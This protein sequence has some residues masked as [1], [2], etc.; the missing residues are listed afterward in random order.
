MT[1]SLHVC[2]VS[3]SRADYG[4]LLPPMRAIQ[5]DPAFRLSM[6]LTGQ[7]L[8]KDAG[9]TAARVRAD[10]FDI[11]AEIDM[12]LAGDDA[13]NVIHACGR[14]LD[15]MAD[16]LARL[17]PDLL[18]VLGDRY[19]ILCCVLAATLARIPIAHI[20]GGDI[21]EGAFDEGF[22]H[23][24][25]KMS[26]LHFVTNADAAVRVRQM[27][28][29]NVYVTGSPALD[30]IRQTP[31]LT[32]D[33][34]FSRLGLAPAK[35][36]ILVTFHP[37]TL[38]KDSLAQFDEVLAALASLEDTAIVIT[39]SNADPEGRQIDTRAKAFVRTHANSVFRPSLGIECYLSA[40]TH[41]DIVAGNS[42][43]G[44]TE[45]PS[46][47][48]PTVNIGTRQHGRPKA[49]SVI[50]TPSQ[51]RDILL[52]LKR[53]KAFGRKDVTNP[54]GD[55]HSSEKIVQILYTIKDPAALLHKVPNFSALAK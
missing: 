50:D 47:G 34:F 45:A 29:N 44:L 3:G 17:Q 5:A 35:T 1:K 6:I 8:V 42:S 22:R 54:Y 33:A 2:A 43:S 20:A 27:G 52:A 15:G 40:L 55:G 4:L 28:E 19:E 26:H 24:I 7:H 49:T 10:G 23:A 32:R 14:V 30:L 16:A 37:V 51:R 11:A 18:L 31:I 38:A 39:G 46:F 36:N 41:M 25:T 9:D 13:P 21:T 48:I 12:G 53:A